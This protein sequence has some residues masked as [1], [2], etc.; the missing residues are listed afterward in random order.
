MVMMLVGA[1]AS[2]CLFVGLL[3]GT[4]P[5]AEDAPMVLALDAL[6]ITD[7]IAAPLPE[8]D[9]GVAFRPLTTFFCAVLFRIFPSESWWWQAV[10]FVVHL[11]VLILAVRVLGRIVGSTAAAAGGLIYAVHPLHAGLF[12]AP[13]SGLAALG[14]PLLVLACMDRL[15]AYRERGGTLRFTACLLTMGLAGLT[16]G[17]VGIPFILLVFD[18][19]LA[20]SEYAQRLRH[21]AT[22]QLSLFATYGLILFGRYLATGAMPNLAHCWQD[23]V[24]LLLAAPFGPAPACIWCQW[25]AWGFLVLCLVALLGRAVIDR[26][27]FPAAFCKVFVLLLIAVALQTEWADSP[28]RSVVALPLPLLFFASL[29]GLIFAGPPSAEQNGMR[30]AVT[31]C[32]SLLTS[33]AMALVSYSLC[34]AIAAA[35]QQAVSAADEIRGDLVGKHH[36]QLIL[37]NEPKKISL[38][39]IPVATFL[40]N[41]LV[42]RLWPTLQELEITPFPFN[43]DQLL[44]DAIRI[45]LATRSGA[46]PFEVGDDG[47]VSRILLS[48]QKI[49]ETLKTVRESGFDQPKEKMRLLLEKNGFPFSIVPPP[50]TVGVR[51]V[52]LTPL[53]VCIA[54]EFET[55]MRFKSGRETFFFNEEWLRRRLR[56][57]DGGRFVA[58]IEL[59]DRSGKLIQR[60]PS[61][62]FHLRLGEN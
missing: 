56:L 57:F 18:L 27:G 52:L 15:A 42:V 44:S 47:K 16:S 11:S 53:G 41:D 23:T 45:Y 19:S 36:T 4:G 28:F 29:A 20:R 14:P 9:G 55:W 46:I 34:S 3:A 60:T 30:S 40:G 38:G 58:W 22:L 33:T 51:A 48:H 10:L 21:K 50:E 17:H 59:F 13:L 61:V 43:S 12:A 37:Y 24:V 35:D 8:P 31:I 1:I 2:G 62:L 5:V 7:L 49:H 32:L 25:S 39:P 54:D 26:R 6:P